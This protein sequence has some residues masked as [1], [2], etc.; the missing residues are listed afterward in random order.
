MP[1]QPELLTDDTYHFFVDDLLTLADT[2]A[3]L[4][5]LLPRSVGS[6][7]RLSIDDTIGEFLDYPESSFLVNFRMR[8]ESFWALVELL[9]QRGGDDYW[10]Q[11]SIGP[12]GGSTGGVR[13]LV[14]TSY[15]VR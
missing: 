1:S 9:E 4:R 8:P 6:A 15:I 10:C 14:Q 13:T 2:L 7:G 11:Q 12:L 5:Y 3:E